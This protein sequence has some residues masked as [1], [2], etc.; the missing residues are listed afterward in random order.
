[1]PLKKVVLRIILVGVGTRRRS[2]GK[3]RKADEELPPQDIETITIGSTTGAALE[4]RAGN[5]GVSLK[6]VALPS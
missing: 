1:M 2:E 5:G 6:K 4:T 3:V